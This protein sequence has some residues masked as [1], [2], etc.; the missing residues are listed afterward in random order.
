MKKTIIALTLAIVIAA[1]TGNALATQPDTSQAV[2][3]PLVEAQRLTLISSISPY[4]RVS[5]LSLATI[6]AL[7]GVNDKVEY[8]VNDG[9]L[10]YA[11]YKGAYTK[12]LTTDG[13]HY[14]QA[15][16]LSNG[17]LGIR[18][19][20]CRRW[21]LGQRR[22]RTSTERYKCKSYMGLRF[23]RC[24]SGENSCMKGYTLSCN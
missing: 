12:F 20:D 14:A 3:T 19:H 23:I 21:Q 18:S 5:A 22:H 4:L 11:G 17:T 8:G 24:R 2:Q 1:A 13:L 7:A 9:I 6:S 15:K 16:V 10:W